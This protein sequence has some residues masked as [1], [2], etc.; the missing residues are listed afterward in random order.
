MRSRQFG[1]AKRLRGALAPDGSSPSCT[2]ISMFAVCVARHT[3]MAPYQAAK[4]SPR[5]VA[6][7][8]GAATMAAMAAIQGLLL[9]KAEDPK[10][11]I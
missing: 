5:L 4:S 10:M 8:R 1:F 6:R 3:P 9:T 11:E 2:G 7:P